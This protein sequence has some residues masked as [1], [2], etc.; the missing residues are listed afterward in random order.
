MK[1]PPPAH[2]RARTAV[3]LPV[4]G[5]CLALLGLWLMRAMPL[6]PGTE[7][8]WDVFYHVRLADLGPSAFLAKT[9]P[10]TAMSVW[11][12]FYYDKELLFHA[13]LMML[14]KLQ[15][16]AG[17]SLDPPFIFPHLV[18]SALLL[19]AFAVLLWRRGCR[20]AWTLAAT[21][22]LALGSPAFTGRLLLLRPHLLAIAI[23]LLFFLWCP[24][25]TTVRS[26][27]PAALFGMLMAYAYSNP[28]FLLLPAFAWGMVLAWDKRCPVYAVLL[29]VAAAAGIFLG[30]L[31]HPQAPNTFFLWKIQCVDV[32]LQAMSGTAPVRVGGELRAP[33]SVWFLVHWYVT[34]ALLVALLLATIVRRRDRQLPADARAALFCTLVLFAGLLLSARV[35]EYYWPFCLL[36]LALLLRPAPA[37]AKPYA[38]WRLPATVAAGLVAALLCGWTLTAALRRELLPITGELRGLA[39]YAHSNLPA[40]TAIANPCWSDFPMLF[41]SLPEYRFSLGM[42]PM[43]AY[44]AHPDAIA[45]LERFRTGRQMLSPAKLAG[46]TGAAYAYVS[47]H[48]PLLAQDMLRHGYAAVYAGPDGWLF[49]LAAR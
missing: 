4:A 18:F 32:V 19:T 23:M 26:A 28:H 42:E 22:L 20:G 24:R 5:V 34:V 17:F 6:E 29:P 12:S 39:A 7:N 48:V 30:L 31:L 46:L 25:V 1:Q 33:G 44:A 41:Y 16:G 10:W 27:W 8:D 14:R 47:Q 40:E 11:D 45:K 37:A 9:F 49:D 13:G 36:S 38:R 3:L 43:F 35:I 21:L 15:A 2:T